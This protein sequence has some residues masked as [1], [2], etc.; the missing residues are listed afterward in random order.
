MANEITDKDRHGGNYA[1]DFVQTRES[2]ETEVEE[3]TEDEYGEESFCIDSD[4]E[5]GRASALDQVRSTY[6][7]RAKESDEHP[8]KDRDISS[9]IKESEESLSMLRN[10]QCPPSSL[11]LTQLNTTQ[12]NISVARGTSENDHADEDSGYTIEVGANI[13][14][15][16]PCKQSFRR[17][18]LELGKG[19]G[20]GGITVSGNIL[21]DS[22]PTGV[23]Q[24]TERDSIVLLSRGDPRRPLSSRSRA[25]RVE[26]KPGI[27]VLSQGKNKSNLKWSTQN[28]DDEDYHA[29]VDENAPGGVRRRRKLKSVAF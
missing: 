16:S 11:G 2:M 26:T 28:D 12:S 23:D 19:D 4:T 13:E 3:E 22:P 24:Y 25:E 6:S 9:F 27:E 21:A 20:N 15:L 14:L 29:E 1:G 17:D 7:Q 10:T 8:S 5:S 18:F